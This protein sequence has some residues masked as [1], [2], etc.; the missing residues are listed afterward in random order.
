MKKI[1]KRNWLFDLKSLAV[2]GAMLFAG[3][4]S[5]QLNGTY[6]IDS[7]SVTGGTNYIDFSAFATA[8][9]A[10]GVSG[11]VTVNVV[12]GSGPYS[13]EL[14]LEEIS[15]SSS[16]NAITI[17]GNGETL[18]NGN[19]VIELEGTDYITVNN[20]RIEHSGTN[21][22]TKIVLCYDEVEYVTFDGCEVVSSN[23]ETYAGYPSYYTG[24][25]FWFGNNN[26]YYQDPTDEN[27]NITINN[28]KTWQGTVTPGDKGKNFGIVIGNP[29]S[30][31]DGQNVT[32]TN[33]EI[34]DFG[35]RGMTFGNST[36]LNVS[37]NEIHNLYNTDPVASYGI[38]IDTY[39]Y[40][41]TEKNV[42]DKNY[43]HDITAGRTNM[44]ERCFY[45]YFGYSSTDCDLTNNIFTTSNGS[46]Q[47]VIDAGYSVNYSGAFN[48]IG[49]TIR[50]YSENSTQTHR[51]IDLYYVTALNI[52]NNVIVDE[53]I[54]YGG[55][56]H[57]IYEGFRASGQTYSNN[58][59][60]FGRLTG[61]SIA[62]GKIFHGRF[63]NA[64]NKTTLNDWV[65]ATG[66]TDE[67]GA[68]PGFLDAA[69][70][71]FHP[72][73]IGMANKGGVTAF[74]LDYDGTTR[75][76]TTP[77]IGAYEY[78][79]DVEIVSVDMTNTMLECAPL[80]DTVVMTVKNNSSFDLT[81]I[82][83]MYSVNGGRA[84]RE[85][86]TDTI[87]AG[88]SAS[89]RFTT[90]GSFNGSNTHVVTGAVDGADD[91][92][93]NSDATYTLATNASPTGGDLAMNAQFDGY[94][95]AG[96]MLEPD[97]TVNT[98]LSNYDISRPAKY[99]SSAPGTDYSYAIVAS[100]VSDST[101]AVGFTIVGEELQIDPSV[102][103]AGETVHMEV[104]VLDANTGCDTTINRYVY[105]PHTPVPSFDAAD[106]C[107]GNTSQFK[108]TSTLGGTSYVVTSWEFADPDVTVTD[109]NSDIKDGFWEY[110]TYGNN[111][112]VEMT[113]ANGQYPKFEYTAMNTINVTPKPEIDFKVLN[114]CEGTP[115]TIINSTTLPTTDPISYT[116]DFAGEATSTDANPAYTFTTPG[117]RKIS[118]TASA[119]GCDATL[120]KNAYQ[121]EKPV[122]DFSNTGECNFVDVVF[123]N[124]STIPNGAGMGY[125]WDF[126]SAA[127]SREEAPAYAFATAGAKTVVLTATSEFGCVDA[128]SK[129]VNLNVS[130]E[131]DFTFDKACNLT[132]INFERT[133]TA[134]ASQS[135]W[136]WDFDGE[137]TSGQENPS[138]LFSK[139]GTKEITLTIADMNG[140]TNSI[141]KELEV[142][143]QAVADFEAGSVCEGDEAVFT[144][145]STVAAGDLTYVW[146]F[147]DGPTATST[148][149]SPTY[150]YT[151]PRT[152][153]VTLEA[154]VAGGC[155][156]IVTKPVTVNPAPVAAFT[157]VKDGRSVVFNGPEGNDQYRWTF[158]D[159]G[160]DQMEDPT[161][162]YVNQDLATLEAC[163]A[164][165]E[166][167]CW[168]ESCETISINL[169]GV[170][171]LTKNNSMINVYPNPSNGQFS[172]T[173]ENA[174]EVEVKVGDILGNTMNASVVDNLN[175][176]YSV[177]MSAVAD[178][179]YFVQVK[180]GDFYATKRITV[181]K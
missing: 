71:D 83:L 107:L 131:A 49:N 173:V 15:G 111:V 168:N 4:A 175:G 17:N 77:D 2:F 47:Y 3:S 140:C 166:G 28:C 65:T 134:N 82:P 73:S 11:A 85:V 127:I 56:S 42:F 137:S 95:N 8:I 115:I 78:Y 132:K 25:Y 24:S 113:V 94:F 74:T 20:L 108:N 89:Y 38:Y 146:T 63:N 159:G 1:Y 97:A 55:N 158:G 30:F 86:M 6:T 118:V 50:M 170:D 26:F 10:G 33:N 151:T 142:V 87:L 150:A 161:Y 60:S 27:S 37:G 172:V 157:F 110:T 62:A 98:Y 75:S 57:L 109:D 21:S 32:I 147:G 163:L 99:S 41:G 114:A 145:N 117:Q 153:N 66:G 67:I 112:N 19:T 52:K 12:V 34:S 9:N 144:N 69:A 136:A 36:G 81:N 179:V 143:L 64:A 29:S 23:S 46:Y 130:P 155:N 101:A 176:T 72:T 174:G 180:N 91:L 139:V 126:N 39:F 141:T 106:I 53:S 61:P 128:V 18:E 129:V 171:E 122:A 133:G 96:T 103:L 48:I 164:T 181:S 76:T 177:D 105:V 138:Y 121:F 68:E 148:D 13:E 16:T 100:K 59:Y 152:Y 160:K 154:I 120:I 92:P 51:G 156:S 178:G 165:K 124:E 84:V 31:T 54:N 40:N 70:G 35:Q 162:T 125:A 5:A 116:W 123:A 90:I 45:F 169:V 149:L 135:T 119:N 7:G 79:V 167:E 88:A 14:H 43:V 22:G 104:V 93:A 80:L 102:T 58:S 44:G